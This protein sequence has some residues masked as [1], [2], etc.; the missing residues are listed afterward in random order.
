MK[1]NNL[2]IL[3][4]FFCLFTFLFCSKNQNTTLYYKV[5]ESD[6]IHQITAIGT[7]EA[8][9]VVAINCPEIRPNP[10]VNTLAPEGSFIRKDEIVCMLKADEIHTNYATTLEVLEDTRAELNK[11]KAQ[12]QLDKNL[13][14]AEL[15]TVD[16][17]LAIANLQLPQLEFLPPNRQ[18]L[19][20]LEL[21]RANIEKSKI[22]KK[23]ASLDNIQ[24]SELNRIHAKI[25]QAE[26]KVS[27]CR[28]FIE[29]LTIRSPIDGLVI[30]ETNWNTGEKMKEG[31]DVWEGMPIV[32]IPGMNKLQVTT[33]VRETYIKRIA[34]D[35]R[36]RVFLDSNPKIQLTGQVT[37]IANMGKPIER[38]SPVKAFEVI[39]E[40]DST[41]A[42]V[43]IGVNAT[44]HII[45]EERTNVIAIPKECIFEQDSLSI[46]YVKRGSS[47]ETRK[48]KL[49]S[50][51]D[52]L[53]LVE[54][55]LSKGDMLAL[56]KPPKH[57]IQPIDE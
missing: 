26:N 44:C 54:N 22:Q 49:G 47:F 27:R 43:P 14:E 17:S 57:T 56:L 24:T 20:Q 4:Y 36:A 46:A 6:F 23:L 25:T 31:D 32:K 19:I 55:G 35:Q 1:K 10:Q 21:K 33:Q 52:D 28:D 39:V 45:V 37:S 5:T 51:N 40:L 42:Q 3:S 53:T 7:V 2:F 29:K 48:L 18:K 13:L 41:T 16:A 8:K 38:D 34:K 50:S 9:H 12:L 15:K 11:T 30:Y